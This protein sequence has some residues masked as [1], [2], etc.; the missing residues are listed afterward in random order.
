VKVIGFDGGHQL[1]PDAERL[2]RD[3]MAFLDAP[4]KA[5]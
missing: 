5:K 2:F 1:P 3:A 4:P